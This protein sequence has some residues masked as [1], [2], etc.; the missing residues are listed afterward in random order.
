M[1]SERGSIT[2]WMVG[3]VMVVLAVGGIAVDLWRGL[4]AH[5]HVASVA[6]AAAVA[7][8]AAISEERWRSQGALVLDRRRV[9]D[10]VAE[11]AAAQT[12]GPEVSYRVEVAPDGSTATIETA[13]TVDLTL[14]GLLADAGLDVAAT[15]TAA[16]TLEP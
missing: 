9:A 1:T 13:A 12:G 4:A 15:A 11:A 8:G 16:P 7:A 6:D 10:A 2:L 5:R 3:L 14:L